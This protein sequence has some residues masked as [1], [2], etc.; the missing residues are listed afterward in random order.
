MA[1]IIGVGILD[2]VCSSGIQL[3]GD[4]KGWSRNIKALDMEQSQVTT[5]KRLTLDYTWYGRGS[6]LVDRL[7]DHLSLE[8]YSSQHD[9]Y[10]HYSPEAYPRS[11]V[12]AIYTAGRQ[13]FNKIIRPFQMG[14][15]SSRSYEGTDS[16]GRGQGL[17]VVNNSTAVTYNVER[18]VMPTKELSEDGYCLPLVAVKK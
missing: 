3:E 14:W 18:L 5:M 15:I 13:L 12:Y 4:I 6:M 8:S 10:P 9:F 11:P 1:S 17:M 16:L 2:E 7:G